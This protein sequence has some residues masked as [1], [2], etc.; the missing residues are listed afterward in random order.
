MLGIKVYCNSI[1]PCAISHCT[2]QLDISTTH[3]RHPVTI[4]YIHLPHHG[5][6]KVTVMVRN[7]R[8]ISLLFHVIPPP[9]VHVHKIRLFQTLTLNLKLQGQV[10]RC[11]QRAQPYHWPS[12]YLIWFSFVSYQSDNNSW[13]TATSKFDLEK[14]KVKFVGEVK[15]HRMQPMRLLFVFV[16]PWEKHIRHLE[17]KITQ[18][19]FQQNSPKSN[20]A[21]KFC[22]DWMSGSHSIGQTSKFC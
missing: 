16:W 12:I 14:S 8:L 1:S 22:I 15:S 9:P 20:L 13:V 4:Q 3:R 2:M 17:K 6:P 21:T 18:N 11:G 5:N 19:S 10:H 7:D